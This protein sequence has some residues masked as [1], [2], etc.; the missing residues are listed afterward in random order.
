LKSGDHVVVSDVVYGGTMRLFREVLDY[1]GITASFVDS[2]D[3][4]NV[5]PLL[6]LRSATQFFLPSITPS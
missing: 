4:G 1:L 3:A 2:S 5:E 6:R